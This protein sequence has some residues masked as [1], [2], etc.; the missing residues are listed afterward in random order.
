[1]LESLMLRKGL[2]LESAVTVIVSFNLPRVKMSYEI[3]GLQ[4]VI[5]NNWKVA[6]FGK[7]RVSFQCVNFPRYKPETK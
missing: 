5:V 6:G 4:M 1:M 3:S 2:L 7:L